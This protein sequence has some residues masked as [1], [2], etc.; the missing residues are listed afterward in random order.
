[1]KEARMHNRATNILLI[2]IVIGLWLNIVTSFI[3]PAIAVTQQNS[4]YTLQGV[5]GRLTSIENNLAEIK[6][7]LD[8]VD[9]NVADIQRGT[10]RNPRIC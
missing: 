5:Y 4:G 9:S 3:N 10:C 2:I 1:M 7:K 8:N 6:R